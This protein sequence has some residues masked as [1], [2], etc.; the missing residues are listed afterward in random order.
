MSQSIIIIMI[1]GGEGSANHLKSFYLEC[2]LS[3]QLE[4]E[5]IETV[6][7]RAQGPEVGL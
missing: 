4:V 6:F 5:S 2:V 3:E 7:F 1:L